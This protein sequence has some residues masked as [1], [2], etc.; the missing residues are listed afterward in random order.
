[1][2]TRVWSEGKRDQ[3]FLTFAPECQMRSLCNELRVGKVSPNES[4]PDR[5]RL[6]SWTFPECFDG[7]THDPEISLTSKQFWPAETSQTNVVLSIIRLVFEL[8][9]NFYLRILSSNFNLRACFVKLFNFKLSKTC[10]KSPK[11]N[12]RILAHFEKMSLACWFWAFF[13]KSFLPRKMC[14][15]ERFS[16]FNL[17]I[18]SSD[19]NFRACSVKMNQNSFI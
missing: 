9:Q 4:S 7:R 11:L 17:Q 8:K 15:N 3:R 10:W 18:Q 13:E 14:Q 5:R 1:M 6:I 16:N 2:V 19:F 12:K